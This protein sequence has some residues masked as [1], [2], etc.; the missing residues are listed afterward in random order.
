M[1][2]LRADREGQPWPLRIPHVYALA[3]VDVDDRH[4]VAV[5]V[6][7]VQR[8]VV[9]GQPAALIEAQ[10]QVRARDP[11]VRDAQV[12]VLITSD[13]NLMTRCEGTL[14]PVVPNC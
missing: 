2:L 12:G 8:A 13:D 1:P 10:D 3:V 7:P 4:P 5:D 14:G 11:R 6:G 9:D